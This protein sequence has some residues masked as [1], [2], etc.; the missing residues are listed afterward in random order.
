MFTFKSG[1][2]N[3]IQDCKCYIEQKTHL[4]VVEQKRD[5]EEYGRYI[6]L[7]GQQ[8]QRLKTIIFKGDFYSSTRPANYFSLEGSMITMC[9]RSENQVIRMSVEDM[10]NVYQYY[11]RHKERIAKF[12]CM[13][14]KR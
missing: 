3:N 13:F 4:L 9:C 10:A 7:T 5:N 12:D 2:R 8:V 1:K 11:E 14:R 6:R